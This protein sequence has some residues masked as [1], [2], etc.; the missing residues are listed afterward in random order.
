MVKACSYGEWACAVVNGA[1]MSKVHVL[2]LIQ[3]EINI[4]L[5]VLVL[6]LL[7]LKCR[8]FISGN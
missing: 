6:L 7:I 4:I 2:I 3:F 8:R 1:C 5:P